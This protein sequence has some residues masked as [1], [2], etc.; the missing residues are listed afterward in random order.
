[1]NE[2]GGSFWYLI[3]LG[4]SILAIWGCYALADRKGYS[5]GWAIV[6]GFLFGVIA[7]LV[8]ALL[9]SKILPRQ[10][11]G[12]PSTGWGSSTPPPPTAEP[13]PSLPP[14]PPMPPNDR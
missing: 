14:P 3:P 10:H 5:T 7:L 6:F 12:P 4:I 8:Y 13:P 11:P 1:M 9:P 2:G